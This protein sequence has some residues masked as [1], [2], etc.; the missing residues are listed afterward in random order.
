L[1]IRAGHVQDVLR[2]AVVRLSVACDESCVVRAQGSVRGLKLRGTLRRLDAGKR[3]VHELLVSKRI[4]DALRR[5]G[6]V[7]VSV[8]GRDAAGNL[9]TATLRVRVKRR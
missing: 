5:S 9:R 6:S 8:R 1:R 7:V 2:R 3:V 4:R